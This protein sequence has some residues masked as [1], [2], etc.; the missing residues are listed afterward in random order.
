MTLLVRQVGSALCLMIGLI[1]SMSWFYW[2]DSPLLM[3]IVGGI[4]VLGGIVG[5]VF[6]IV[7]AEEELSKD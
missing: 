3:L 5:V 7:K 1:V 4:L 6:T 2:K